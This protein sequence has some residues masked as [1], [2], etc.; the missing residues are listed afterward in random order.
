MLITP[1][2]QTR[3]LEATFVFTP[4]PVAALTIKPV[5]L[6]LSMKFDARRQD[7]LPLVISRFTARKRIA[8]AEHKTADARKSD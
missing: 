3:S 8:A 5:N 2:F 7:T 6:L 4:F 1:K